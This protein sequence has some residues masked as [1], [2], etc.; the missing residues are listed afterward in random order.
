MKKKLTAALGA[1]AVTTAA[2]LFGAAGSAHALAYVVTNTDAL[3][4][5]VHVHSFGQPASS[6]LCTYTAVPFKVPPGV[7]P[8]APVYKVP[9][10]LQ[11]NGTHDLWFPGV[12]TGTK[13]K[14]AIDCEN[15]VDSVTQEVVY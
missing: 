6:G 8:P 15:G 10:Y 11:A 13:W 14:L 1:A 9:F 5:T 2:L 4:V 7:I 3:G 12:Q